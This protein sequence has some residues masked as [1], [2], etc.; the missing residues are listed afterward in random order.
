MGHYDRSV[1]KEKYLD[2]S[3]CAAIETVPGRMAGQP[4]IRNSRVRPQ[5]LI[6]NREQGVEWLARNH[7]LPI[8]T[9]QEVLA[10]YE[11]HERALAPSS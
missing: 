7:S 6:A 1:M 5:D 11:Q 9:V 10:F 4:V 2:W 3:T 8:E